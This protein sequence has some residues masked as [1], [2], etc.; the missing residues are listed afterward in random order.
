MK[1]AKA[2]LKSIV[3]D[4]EDSDCDDVVAGSS[5]SKKTPVDSEMGRMVCVGG[6]CAWKAKGKEDDVLKQIRTEDTAVG[7]SIKKTGECGAEL[8]EFNATT[9]IPLTSIS[10][11]YIVIDRPLHHRIR[12]RKVKEQ[13][14]GLV[15]HMA[16]ERG[17]RSMKKI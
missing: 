17:G 14:Q 11:F 13:V 6:A 4:M 12:I 16:S 1:K 2:R 3:D 5:R 9:T 8:C 15:G 10:F 7:K